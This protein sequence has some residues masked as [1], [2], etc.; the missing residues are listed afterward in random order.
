[1]AG[2][3][4]VV[5]DSR[6]LMRRSLQA[7]L[8]EL[9]SLVEQVEESIVRAGLPLDL[10]LQ[11]TLAFDEVLTN[12]ASHAT[13]A[14]GRAVSVDIV[15]QL[16]A[17][18]L[19]ATVS[20]DGPA[21]DMTLVADPDLDADLD[22]RSIGGLGLFIVRNVMD[23]VIHDR[24]GSQNRLVLIKRLDRSGPTEDGAD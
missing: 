10:G 17:D 24:L 5:P 23:E 13:A 14:A 11:F 21:F 12:I 7:S 2:S 1:M 22:E 8:A 6:V 18:R 16:F 3:E 15:L 20:D 19:Q 4:T 9:P